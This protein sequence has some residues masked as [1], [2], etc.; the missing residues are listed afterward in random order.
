[1]IN[2]EISKAKISSVLIINCCVANGVAMICYIIAGRSFRKEVEDQEKVKAEAL[3][4]AI[5]KVPE[6][7]ASRETFVN[8]N[9]RISTQVD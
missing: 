5:V 8:N 6:F 3:A 2:G 4:Q 1:M 9:A 7:R